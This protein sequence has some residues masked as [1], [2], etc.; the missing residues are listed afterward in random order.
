MTVD[1]LCE[2]LRRG[3]QPARASAAIEIAIRQRGDV[4]FEVRAAGGRQRQALDLA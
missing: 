4:V 3:N 1:W 2:V